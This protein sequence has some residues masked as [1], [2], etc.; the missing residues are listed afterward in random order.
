V[1]DG[2]DSIAP[3]RV[4]L[5]RANGATAWGVVEGA[6]DE[7][8]GEVAVSIGELGSIDWSLATPVSGEVNARVVAKGLVERSVRRGDVSMNGKA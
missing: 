3:A 7:A 6:I 4:W 1:V 5:A 2:R 8:L